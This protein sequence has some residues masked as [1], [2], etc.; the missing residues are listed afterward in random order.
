MRT[1]SLLSASTLS[2]VNAP[3]LSKAIA[4]SD[5]QLK[6]RK[7]VPLQLALN[8][9][10]TPA[11]VDAQL[12]CT[13]ELPF[14]FDPRTQSSVYATGSFQTGG[15]HLLLPRTL[16][17]ESGR[18]NRVV[19]QDNLM[20][21]VIHVAP[22][23]YRLA[24]SQ[25]APFLPGLSML[26]ADFGTTADGDEQAEV[27]LNVVCSYE[28]E[29]WLDPEIVELARAELAAEG[30]TAR[31]TPIVP[32]VA[33]LTLELDL[34]GDEKRRT[35]AEIETSVGIAD[36]LIL[37]H[38]A[39]TRLWREHLANETGGVTGAVEYE[40]FDGTP[41][42]SRVDLSLWETSPDVFDID[43]LGMVE[44]EPGRCRVRIRNRIE[45]PVEIVGLP[46][47]RL[48]A[49]A[50]AVATNGA[51]LA[52]RVL[53]PQESVEV[54]YQVNPPDAFVES[55]EPVV[56]GRVQ[57]DL[58]ALLK[59]FVLNSGYSSMS[60]S[61]DVSAADGVFSTAAEGEEPLTGLLVEFDDGSSA[62]LSPDEPEIEVTLVGRLIDQ[63]TGTAGEQQRYFYRV[64]NLHPGGE[65]ARTAWRE[66]QGTDPIVVGTAVVQLDF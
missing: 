45:S 36:T 37:D 2:R 55:L 57:P 42:R 52:G 15:I 39:F 25:D 60:F 32:R 4:S 3:T 50:T 7:V 23:E 8:R 56:F 58:N 14:F 12:D 64:T 6:N 22:T 24:R 53:A 19:Y 38:E 13:A 48:S 43:F 65:G 27:M 62:E 59:L 29:P 18:T 54:D 10:G 40:L 21:E 5:L 66:G 16:T 51:A 30:L 26:C 9:K 35:E 41:A 61:V 28:L 1:K 20:P 33:S 31:F 17:D 46:A 63:L 49:D 47:E 34:L 11:V 44:D